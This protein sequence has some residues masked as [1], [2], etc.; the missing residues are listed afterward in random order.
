MSTLSITVPEQ[1]R[2]DLCRRFQENPIPGPCSAG[3]MADLVVHAINEALAAIERVAARAPD[4]MSRIAVQTIAIKEAAIGFRVI[5]AE[6]VIA[7]LAAGSSRP[8][9]GARL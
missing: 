5:N 6:H 7:I 1:L 9:A 3:E 2:S 8:T 4:D